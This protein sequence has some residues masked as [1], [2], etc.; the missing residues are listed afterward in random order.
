MLPRVRIRSPGIRARLTLSG[1]DVELPY[2]FSIAQFEGADPPAAGPFRSGGSDVDQVSVHQR[3]HTN[4][5]AIFW[6]RDLFCPQEVACFGVE[7]DQIVVSCA[8]D[9]LS[10]HNGG[11]TVGMHEVAIAR[12]PFVAPQNVAISTI[13]CDGV[14][15]ACGVKNACNCERGSLG[16]HA[17]WERVR[18]NFSKLTHILRSDLIQRTITRPAD[19]VV[20]I[21]PVTVVRPGRT[22]NERYPAEAMDRFD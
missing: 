11:A 18:A 8:A 14:M 19:I 5:V 2:L 12:F 22:G 7:R 1:N 16:R 21:C 3:R 4:K 15:I 10:T 13:E 6:I 17:L 20:H 9:N